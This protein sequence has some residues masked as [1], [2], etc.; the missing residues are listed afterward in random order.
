M[1]LAGYQRWQLVQKQEQY[2]GL[3]LKCSQITS[4]RESI[5]STVRKKAYQEGAVC[6]SLFLT[7]VN[8][9]DTETTRGILQPRSPR[10]KPMH[11]T[12]CNH[13]KEKEK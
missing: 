11:F 10:G 5:A 9:V 6:G 4:Q 12:T 2:R 13:L 1:G 8:Q 3:F 7:L